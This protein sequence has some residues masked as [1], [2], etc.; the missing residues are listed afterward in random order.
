MTV[1]M[2]D[3]GTILVTL[4]ESDM[5]AYTLDFSK[6]SDGSREGLTELLYR[7]GEICGLGMAGKSF[8]IE[9]L[10][11]S[12]GCLLIIT[13][14][15]VRRRRVYRVKREQRR[16]I[17]VLFDSDAL[18]DYLDRGARPDF[19]LCSYRGSYIILPEPYAP[20]SAVREL[21]EYG[22]LQSVSPAVAARITEFGK[23]LMQKRN[24]RRYPS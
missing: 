10:P 16:N 5:R 9:A 20:S 23:V 12:G 7:V 15:A 4:G 3:T 24:H 2:L 22:S 17:C 14:R 18:L 6:G 21:C 19:T 13:A 11:S 8:L 1:D